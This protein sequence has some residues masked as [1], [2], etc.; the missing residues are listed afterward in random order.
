[1]IA[2]I[3]AEIVDALKASLPLVQVE[4]FPDQPRDYNLMHSR[5]AVLVAYKGREREVLTG[6]GMANN[7]YQ[8]VVSFLFRNLRARDAH[9][10]IYD[11]LELAEGALTDIATLKNERF[12]NFENGV[13]EYSQ[14]YR[15][16][17]I[18]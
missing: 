4:A 5:G 7:D 6:C 16:E 18:N 1:M 17:Q 3:E 14:L 8:F 10:G 9:Q 12:V 11:A 13:W 15:V 2:E